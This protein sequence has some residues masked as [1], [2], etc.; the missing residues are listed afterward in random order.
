MVASDRWPSGVCCRRSGEFGDLHPLID[1]Y[2][3]YCGPHEHSPTGRS[4]RSQQWHLMFCPAI[5]SREASY[6]SQRRPAIATRPAQNG[7]LL[8]HGQGRREGAGLPHSAAGIRRVE[9]VSAEVPHSRR[10]AGRVGRLVVLSLERGVVCGQRLRRGHDQS[11]RIDGLRAG[12]CR[13]RERRLGRQALHRPDDGA[14]LRRDSTIP[15]ST[16]RANARSARA[17]AATWPTGSSAT[18]TA[19]SA[20]SRTTACSIPSRPTARPKR[21]WFNEW[22][23]KGK[24]WDY[25]GKPDAENP[26]RKWSPMLSAKNFKTP[27]LVIHSQLDYRLDV[28][29]GYQLFDTLQR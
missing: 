27:T 25:Y 13:R 5:N 1:G 6:S 16:R 10:A 19:S 23:F 8:V 3:V 29:E 24:P 15:S 11:A 17:T 12:L 20:S 22:E 7:I 26:Y 4:G 21:L 2:T 9:E 14:R 28:S 18:P